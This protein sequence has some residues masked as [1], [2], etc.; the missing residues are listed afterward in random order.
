ALL[1]RARIPFHTPADLHPDRAQVRRDSLLESFFDDETG[2]TSVSDA[3]QPFPHV[4]VRGVYALAIAISEQQTLIGE[5]PCRGGCHTIKSLCP[6]V[7][8]VQRYV[9]RYETS[10]YAVGLSCR[11][12]I[13]VIGHAVAQLHCA[14]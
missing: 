3:A 8:A 7:V 6:R 4:Q 10:L 13:S 5:V 1:V 11:A 2:F 12:W 14:V 9:F